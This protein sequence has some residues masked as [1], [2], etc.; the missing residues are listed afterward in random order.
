M[1]LFFTN[2]FK[3][4]LPAPEEALAGRSTPIAV[5]HPHAVSGQPCCHLFQRD[6]GKSIWVRLLLGRERLFWQMDGV[7]TTAVGYMGSL[8]KN[9]TYEEVCSGQTGHTEAVW[10]RPSCCQQ[11]RY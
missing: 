8:T 5:L 6:T 3:S 4:R 1:A 11:R 7:W 10:S 2:P 9:P